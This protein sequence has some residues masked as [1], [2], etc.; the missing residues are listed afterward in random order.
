[1]HQQTKIDKENYSKDTA[2]L[3]GNNLIGRYRPSEEDWTEYKN[4]IQMLSA[5]KRTS[6]SR[7]SK[8]KGD[9]GSAENVYITYANLKAHILR[10]TNLM[11]LKIE[12]KVYRTIVDFF[13]RLEENELLAVQQL[14]SDPEKYFKEYYEPFNPKDTYTLVYEGIS[15]AYHSNLDC[16]ALNA[17][18]ENFEVPAEFREKGDAEVERFRKWFKPLEDL[19]KTK[20]DL[21]AE[22]F[23]L[24]WGFETNVRAMEA[25][26][27]G[28]HLPPE[29][30]SSTHAEIEL[31][32]DGLLKKATEF[33]S[34]SEKNRIILN[35]FKKH[36]YQGLKKQPIKDNKTGYSDDEVKLVLEE[37]ELRH[38][39]PI[40][41][42]LIE[43][44]RYKLNPNLGFSN[45]I[46]ESL[47]FVA[48]KAC[49][50]RV[51]FGFSSHNVKA[52][53]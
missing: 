19:L 8:K 47:G 28:G 5:S 31:E 44:Y 22:R 4:T 41:K 39:R 49:S 14:F 38:K 7:L 51:V 25:K 18:Y 24:K 9:T 40:K 23:R 48:C 34:C 20:P 43:Y 12:G 50:N 53:I 36:S 11:S 52:T 33:V 17:D 21:F 45:N 29:F 42:L 1:M 35:R 46:L 2:D 3:Y 13:N 16:N 6:I 27:S 32:I 30:E 15:P 26:N 10:K 37:F